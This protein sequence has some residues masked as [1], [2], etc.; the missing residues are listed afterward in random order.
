MARDKREQLSFKLE[1]RR[2]YAN[3]MPV[4]LIKAFIRKCIQPF[5]WLNHL[6]S[7]KAAPAVG[8]KTL[9]LPRKW[10]EMKAQHL[11]LPWG[12]WEAS[13]DERGGGL[14]IE[15]VSG[16]WIH[17]CCPIIEMSKSPAVR[18]HL[19]SSGWRCKHNSFISSHHAQD[20][21]S[22]RELNGNSL[23]KWASEGAS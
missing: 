6:L 8:L 2:S 1:D 22:A 17:G 18:W 13:L 23:C 3:L 19:L 16:R 9:H 14:Y 12:C 15:R 7:P 10:K 11:D 4:T 20:S 5:R 21:V